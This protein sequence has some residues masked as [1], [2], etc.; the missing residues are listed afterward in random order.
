[1]FDM[2]YIYFKK[3]VCIFFFDFILLIFFFLSA[4]LGATI[5]RL[6][7]KNCQKI[8]ISK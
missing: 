1:M 6:K 7:T 2:I 5:S 8:K 3:I 4:V